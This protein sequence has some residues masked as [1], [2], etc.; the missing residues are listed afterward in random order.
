MDILSR[1][2]GIDLLRIISCIA[3]IGIHV[4]PTY[5]IEGAA[6]I[7]DEVQVIL[8]QSVFRIGL[9]IFFVL[10]GMFILNTKENGAFCFYKKRLPAIIIPFL[11][12]SFIHYM[13]TRGVEF[14]I[15]YIKSY[16]HLIISS[17]T[18]L[19]VHFW[20]VYVIIGI[21]IISP[22]IKFLMD[23][24]PNK[25][26]LHAIIIII[27]LS[28]YN[29]YSSEASWKL[30]VPLDIIPIPHIDFWLS[31]FIIGGFIQRINHND[32]NFKLIFPCLFLLHVL[33]VYLY[34]YQLIFNLYP[35]D[36][37]I[38]IFMITTAICLYFKDLEIKS[39][40]NIITKTSQYTYGV[41]LI[42]I[43]VMDVVIKNIG[44]NS[45]SSA[46]VIQ[47]AFVIVIIFSISLL[48]SFIVDN[49]ITKRILR[50]I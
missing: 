22:L 23:K 32:F 1:N 28:V 7:S 38:S 46:P 21:Y 47:S 40:I 39:G 45:L 10:S 33:S 20:F 35:A 41:Y 29:T 30:G 14:N 6:S 5:P 17:Q 19:S 16:T 3:V 34:K 25:Y 50:S 44:N 4:A 31:Y 42:H 36:K 8:M 2:H 26:S 48:I 27:S 43:A 18:A 12:Y 37:G 13:I 49:L 15:N 9:P 24:I 11:I